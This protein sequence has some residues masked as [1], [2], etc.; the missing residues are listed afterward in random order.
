MELTLDQVLK[1][2][3]TAHK[4]G[5]IQ[6]A[7]RL[8]SAILQIQPKHPDANHNMG[9]LAVGLDKIHDSLPFFK[10]AL[11]ANPSVAQF[12]L[13]YIDALIKLDKLTDAQ[14][15]YDQARVKGAGGEAFDQLGQQLSKLHVNPQQ[16]PSNQLQ[17][18]INLYTQGQFQQALFQATE[19][20]VTFP[21]LAVLYN[22]AGASNA[23]LSQIDEAIDNYKQALKIKP[24]Y[25]EVHSNM[26]VAL[27]D[28]GELDAAINSYKQALKIK[29]D[30]AAVYNNIGLALKVK[31]DLEAAINSYKQALIIKPDFADAYNNMGSAQQDDGDPRAAIGS[32]KQALEIKPHDASAYYNM[33]NALRYE[34]DLEAAINSYRQALK[35]KPNYAEAYNNMGSA[36]INK[37]DPEAAINCYK[38][39]LKIK[40]DFAEAFNNMGIALIEKGSLEAAIYSF[41]KALKINPYYAE[42]YNN[43]GNAQNNQGSLEAAIY[44]YKFALKI[45]PDFAEAYRH[46]SSLNHYKEHD[47]YFIMMQSLWGD[48]SIGDEKRC[49]LSFALSK[50]SEDLSEIG[51]SFTYLKMGNEIRKKILSYDIKQDAKLFNQLKK[52]YL[53][54]AKIG[55]QPTA[56]KNELK[57]IFILGMPRS[58]TTLVE[59]IVSSHSEVSGAGELSYVK[60]FG[61]CI[62]NGSVRPNAGMILDFRQSYIEALNSHSN[63]KSFVTD[64]MPHNF[65]YVGLIFLAFPDAKVI[66]VNRD[67]AAT[68]WSNYKHYFETKDLGYSYD[69]DDVA[70]YFG[71]YQDLMQFWQSHFRGRMYNL[72]YDKLTMYQDQETKM[73]IQYLGLE[74]EDN[75]LSPQS[76]ERSVHTASNQQV[77]QKVYQ[78]S[79]QQWRKFEPYISGSFDYL[80]SKV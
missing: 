66:H 28:K 75:C 31:G 14:T 24:D 76:N 37:G 16:P 59:Q 10:T 44:S 36:L 64:K 21:N 34:G 3:V 35:I 43:I 12:W 9:V 47:E 57:P 15:I 20:L 30:Y 45:K 55:L 63:G 61:Q 51:Q 48:P 39:A 1:K 56:E 65:Q 78:G 38:Q 2:G 73:L 49:H 80:V 62:V 50:A 40:P 52:S 71:F 23:G 26:G 72:S 68:C 5:Q 41:N 77:R 53:D 6:E 13:S 74:W 33:G 58:G 46:L 60:K 70:T 8:Y 22:I 32:Y 25:A 11:E 69:L 29:P 54:I 18:I 4:I 27:K 42:A 7:D 19:M 79:S 17:S 67:P